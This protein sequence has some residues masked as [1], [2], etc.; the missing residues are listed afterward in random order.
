MAYKEASKSVSPFIE[1]ATVHCTG[2][3]I[4]MTLFR[5]AGGKIELLDMGEFDTIYGVNV[6]QETFSKNTT[7]LQRKNRLLLLDTATQAGLVN[8][9]HE[10]WH[11]SYGDKA[12]AYVKGEKFAKYGLAVSKDDPILSMNKEEYLKQF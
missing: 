10:W 9:G 7:E 4:D 6:Q 5:V 12:W 11:Y 3:A 2:A 8:Y 1:N